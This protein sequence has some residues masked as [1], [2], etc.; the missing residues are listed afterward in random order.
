MSDAERIKYYR[1]LFYIGEKEK[2][3]KGRDKTAAKA[4]L[5]E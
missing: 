4:H 5:K 2:R 1:D 3:L